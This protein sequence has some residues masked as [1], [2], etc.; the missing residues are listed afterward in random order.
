MPQRPQLAIELRPSA[1]ATSSPRRSGALH[2]PPQSR[3]SQPASSCCAASC[4]RLFLAPHTLRAG[5]LHRLP[6]S[7]Q[8]AAAAHSPSGSSAQRPPPHSAA[9]LPAQPAPPPPPQ[10]PAACCSRSARNPFK[11]LLNL[12]KLRLEPRA[13]LPPVPRR[14][15]RLP[16]DRLAPLALRIAVPLRRQRP[17]LQAPLDARDLRLH[18]PQRR[19]RVRRL[20][21]RLA[22]L[23]RL[24]LH[25]ALQLPNLPLQR[26]PIF[27]S[28]CASSASTPHPPLHLAQLALQR[29]WPLRPTASTRHRR[30]VKRLTRRAQKVSAADAPTPDCRAVSASG[31]MYPSRSFGSMCCSELP[32]PFNART[33]SFNATTPSPFG[34]R[35]AA[36]PPRGQASA[37]P[38]CCASW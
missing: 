7:A 15:C 14:S 23:L 34:V 18:L 35:I 31:A 3:E 29:Q 36:P 24:R 38:P 8:S 28:A 6:Q 22:P 30:V 2:P 26:Q 32:N 10:P 13:L 17:L 9:A 21:L 19:T 4:A 11:P 25:R 16:L 12:R 37:P 27:T 1:R 33:Q 20:P 5:R